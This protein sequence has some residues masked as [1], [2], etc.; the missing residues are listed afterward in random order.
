MT[1]AVFGIN[2]T[3]SLK[4]CSLCLVTSLMLLRWITLYEGERRALLATFVVMG[5]S[6]LLYG[7]PS[8]LSI[9]SFIALSVSM[10]TNIAFSSF[11]GRRKRGGLNFVVPV[12]FAILADALVMFVWEAQTFPLEKAVKILSRCLWYKNGVLLVFLGIYTLTWS[13]RGI[14]LA[15]IDRGGVK[16]KTAGRVASPVPTSSTITK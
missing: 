1:L 3:H 6:V 9:Y 10:G 11:L 5:I 14:S 12:F 15:V 8:L 2:Y 7:K 4:V 16:V 13:L